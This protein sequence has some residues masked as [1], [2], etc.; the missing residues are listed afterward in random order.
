MRAYPR[1]G[2]P[3]VRSRMFVAVL[4]SLIAIG[5]WTSAATASST[6]YLDVGGTAN[7]LAFEPTGEHAYV[8]AA[9]GLVVLDAA[10]RSIEATVALGG[11]PS[12]SPSIRSVAMCLPSPA[13]IWPII[14]PDTASVAGSIHLSRPPG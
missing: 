6:V 10:S 1:R 5:G 9:G 3:T 2:R 7:A 14:D 12:R 11:S 4:G 8:A 13:L